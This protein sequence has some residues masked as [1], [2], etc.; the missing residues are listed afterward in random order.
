MK[1]PIYIPSKGRAGISGT[2]AYF[3]RIGIPF[4]L[5]VEEAERDLYTAHYGAEV[6]RVLPRSFQESYDPLDGYGEEFPLGSGPSRNYAWTLAE[7]TGAKWHWVVDD[8][9]PVL[10]RLRKDSAV[11]IKNGPAYMHDAERYIT[12]FRN[13]GMGG[14]QNFAFVTL[15]HQDVKY[16]VPNTRIYSFNLI[17]TSLPYRWRGRYNEDTILSLDLLTNRWATLLLYFLL[18]QKEETRKVAGG[19]TEHLY[20]TGTGPK[21]RLLARVYPKFV[22]VGYRFGR[23]HHYIDYKKHFGDIPLILERPGDAPA[24]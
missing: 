21:S 4:T 12:Q 15:R 14:P 7:E 16:A 20:R 1:Y 23:I 5:I 11:P 6:V 9:I 19:N 18:M 22:K 24:C 10:Y 2:A 17:R 3:K 13:V 8:N